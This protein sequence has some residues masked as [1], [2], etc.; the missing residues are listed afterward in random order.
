[1]PFNGGT[2]PDNMGVYELEDAALAA[3]QK[4]ITKGVPAPSGNQIATTPFF[5]IVERDQYGN[6]LGGIRLP[7]I[8][9]PTETYSA[10]NFYLPS[11]ESLSPGQLFTRCRA[12]SPPYPRE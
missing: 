10:I 12:S 2:L 1:M 11:Q 7:D 9:A 4:W 3:L 8:Q 6:A 5:N